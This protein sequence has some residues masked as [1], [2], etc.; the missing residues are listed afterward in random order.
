MR[1][2]RE[3]S[4]WRNID[5]LAWGISFVAAMPV[6][7][8]YFAHFALPP[9]GTEGTG[10]LHYDQPYYMANAKALFSN[11]LSPFYGLP[12]S[13]Y[14]T[15][16]RVYFQ[17][18]TIL[19]AFA[20]KITGAQPGYVY[21]AVGAV[22][23]I[24]MFRVSIALVEAFN[25]RQR[26][27]PGILGYFAVLWGGGLV[28]LAGVILWMT[29]SPPRPWIGTS[30]FALDPVEGYWFLN[31]G[32]NALFTTEAVYHA[33]FFGT[34]VQVIRQKYP[35]A[36]VLAAL[37]SCSHPFSGLELLLILLAFVAGEFFVNK[38]TP[39]PRWFI[40]GLVVILISHLAYYLVV[41][42]LLSPE[43]VMLERQWSLPWILPAWTSVVAYGP[44]FLLAAVT[45]VLRFLSPAG[46]P[47]RETRFAVIWFVVAFALAN[48][49]LIISPRQPLHF[50]RGYVWTPL[51]LLA[52]PTVTAAFRRCTNLRW[53]ITALAACAFLMVIITSDNIA[54]FGRNFILRA[55]HVPGSEIFLTADASQTLAFLAQPD[56]RKRLLLSNDPRLAYMATA[57]V[58]VRTWLSHGF[59]TPAAD[60]RREQLR[61]F[62][63]SEGEVPEW[64]HR[65]LVVVVDSVTNPDAAEMLVRSGFR[66]IGKIGHYNLFIR[67]AA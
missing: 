66:P 45:L 60:D 44:V 12:F 24:V 61:A 34:C 30:A 39:P 4:I 63:A 2:T 31:L 67:D 26:D 27:L 62:F 13:P 5:G 47:G 42:K 25:G 16:P 21:A 58:P 22:S 57:Y 9:G 18:L 20:L 49:E 41:L 46:I 7:L 59:N 3:K 50:T 51:A 17:P 40:A 11:G 55:S 56:M 23:A 52:V 37:L 43:H 36:L 28:V 19:F 53:H 65:D 14:D 48:H 1:H 6:L 54:W 29:D 38:I 8:A 35:S 64:R 15:T 32:R 33:L 10:F